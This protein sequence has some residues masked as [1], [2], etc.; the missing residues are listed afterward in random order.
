MCSLVESEAAAC[1]TNP[2]VTRATAPAAEAILRAVEGFMAILPEGS[3]L[4][5]AGPGAA[6]SAY[7]RGR[8]G[9]RPSG[10][11]YVALPWASNITLTLSPK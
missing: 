6:P 2:A 10:T 3:A 8:G 7:R 4:R 5:G 9:R 11:D 1:Q